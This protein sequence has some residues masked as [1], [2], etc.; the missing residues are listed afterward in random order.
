MPS[1]V[2]INSVNANTPANAALPVFT[3]G[4]RQPPFDLA[5]HMTAAW[6]C[7]STGT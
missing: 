7:N 1:R 6:P 4:G 5:L 2:I 3:D